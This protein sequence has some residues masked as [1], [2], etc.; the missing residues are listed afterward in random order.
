M[1]S[2]VTW[3]DTVRGNQHDL[4]NAPVPN[5]QLEGGHEEKQS[6]KPNWGTLC[7]TPGLDT[8]RLVM[9]D[10]RK[11]SEGRGAETQRLTNKE[12][13]GRTSTW[14]PWSL[15]GFWT[16][17]KLKMTYVGQEGEAWVELGTRNDYWVDVKWSWCE[18][19]FH[20]LGECRQL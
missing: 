16:E 4:G 9:E 5:T 19:I 17:K 18:L 7:K 13:A 2:Y 15:T 10:R 1:A 3:F 8:S 6:M 12:N 11:A 20:Y 14:N